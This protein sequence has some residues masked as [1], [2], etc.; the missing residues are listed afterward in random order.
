[1]ENKIEIGSKWF[2]GNTFYPTEST[3]VGLPKW[4]ELPAGERKAW[5][6]IQYWTKDWA[7]MQFVASRVLGRKGLQDL[8]LDVFAPTHHTSVDAMCA[9]YTRKA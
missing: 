6:Q 3:V 8:P 1:M 9:A 4:E 5:Q 7:G 2:S